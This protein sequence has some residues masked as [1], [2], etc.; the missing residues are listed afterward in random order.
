MSSS[1]SIWPQAKE[2]KALSSRVPPEQGRQVLF[3]SGGSALHATCQALVNQTHNSIHL[4]TPFDSG[5]STAELRKHFNIPAVGDLRARLTALVDQKR[6][7]YL[8][9][10]SL[11]SFRFSADVA[12]NE[13]RHFIQ[14]VING[15]AALISPISRPLKKV[16]QHYLT[17]FM[18]NIGREFNF[19]R[20]SMGNLILAGGYLKY[21][22]IEPCLFELSDKMS[23]QGKVR[24]TVND[25]FHLV[26]A[27]ENGKTLVGQ[28]RITG[29][30]S[31]PI[32]SPIRSLHLSSQLEE[33]CP[34]ECQISDI[35][36][37]LIENADL[38]CYP[39]GSF[40][41]SLVANFLPHG[42]AQAIQKNPNAKIFIPNLGNDPESL[43]L[44][45]NDNIEKIVRFLRKNLSV[46]Q[47]CDD[48]PCNLLTHILID[49][50]KQYYNGP[51]NE[52]QWAKFGIRVIKRDLT[53]DKFAPYYDPEKLSKALLSLS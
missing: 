7:D 47:G 53:S 52:T 19:C 37:K 31:Q 5:G 39:P 1:H 20:A 4:L 25:N 35:N 49:H 3:F 23:I 2:A 38:I 24:L 46:I 13:A 41:S 51:I 11:F 6:K 44:S 15:S 33:N 43:G 21:D 18:K 22:Q 9:I 34:V 17:C 36:R 45:T 10:V 32:K 28:H 26:A 14:S 42:V 8:A 40:Y 27:L 12:A 48:T 50:N 16:I 29:K 30:E